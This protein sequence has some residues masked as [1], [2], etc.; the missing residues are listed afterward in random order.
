MIRWE[1]GIAGQAG[2]FGKMGLKRLEFSDLPALKG[3]TGEQSLQH[4]HLR[5]LLAQRPRHQRPFQLQVQLVVEIQ[6]PFRVAVVPGKGENLRHIPDRRAGKKRALPLTAGVGNSPPFQQV[7]Q[8][9]GASLL[10]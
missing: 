5:R 6:K 9:Q 7:D 4:R 8:R 2:Q 1:G 10:R 3:A